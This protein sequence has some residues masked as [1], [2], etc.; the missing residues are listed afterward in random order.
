MCGKPAARRSHR[1]AFQHFSTP[2]HYALFALPDAMFALLHAE[3][4][5]QRDAC[6]CS[7]APTRQLAARGANLRLQRAISRSQ[8]TCKPPRQLWHPSCDWQPAGQVAARTS[9][10]RAGHAAACAVA[11]SQQGNRQLARHSAAHI[12]GLGGHV[13]RKQAREGRR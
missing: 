6:P 11:G 2:P 9:I 7:S 5:C 13:A 1:T 8:P 12:W 10:G 4:C 3:R